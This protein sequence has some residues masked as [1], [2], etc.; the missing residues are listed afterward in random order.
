MRTFTLWFLA[1]LG[2]VQ[3]TY[4]NKFFNHW[5]C[6]GIKNKMDFSKPT[7]VKVGELPLVLWKDGRGELVTTLNIC[8]HMGSRLDNGKITASGCLKCQYHGLE[9]SSNEKFGET[10]EHEGK[11]FWAYE[12]VTKTPPRIPFYNNKNYVKSF[13]EIDMDC[14]LLDSAFNTIDIRHP[15]FVHNLG[16]GNKIPP[17]NVKQ[18]RWVGLG[19]VV[20]VGGAGDRV[21]LAFDYSSNRFIRSINDNV[22]FTR[23]FHMFC[24]PT[25][26]WSRVSFKNNNLYIAANLLPIENKKTRWYIT[27]C[28]N[29]YTSIAGE[30]FMKF[31]A[32]TILNQDF[33]QMRNQ[34]PEN[35]LKREVMFDYTFKNEEVIL[36]LNDIFEEH[37]KF[38]DVRDCAELYKYHKEMRKSDTRKQL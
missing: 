33:V 8:N 21:G 18:Y 38:P 14:S 29:Y 30:E 22:E 2:G 7:A 34:Y 1:L 24:Y 11:I 16:F 15:E 28:H 32:S 37:Y 35:E 3:S 19:G 9:F 26:T 10:V 25:F 17:E 12:P 6:V 27:I 4:N 31:L 5:Q 13:L 36:W 20:G 23:N